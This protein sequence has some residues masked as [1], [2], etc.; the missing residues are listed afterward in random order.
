MND[1]F[2]VMIVLVLLGFFLSYVL[3]VCS[4]M[5]LC[6]SVLWLISLWLMV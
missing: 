4:E 2:V 3:I 6:V 5:F 1:W